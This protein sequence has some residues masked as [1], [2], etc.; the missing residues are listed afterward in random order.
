MTIWKVP[1][2]IEDEQVVRVPVGARPICAREQ[3]N[4]PC[5]WVECDGE[6][7][8]GSMRVVMRGTGHRLPDDRPPYV[9]TA[10]M[11]GGDLVWH[12]FAGGA[13]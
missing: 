5:L 7:D 2:A 4:V 12:V 10:V 8:L 13:S 3:G 6:A 1:L 9:G 11:Y